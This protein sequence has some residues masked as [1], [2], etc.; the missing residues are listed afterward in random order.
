MLSP[1][2][3]WRTPEELVEVGFSRSRVVM[4]NEAHN[5]L[6]RSVRTRRVGEQVLP[7]AHCAGVRGIAIEALMPRFAAEANE[8]RCVPAARGYL[9]QPDMRAL[10]AAALALG[11]TLIPYECDDRVAPEALNRLAIDGVNWREDQQARNLVAELAALPDDGKLL[12][13][14]GNSHHLKVAAD[15][16]VP[17][18]VRFRELSGIDAFTIDQLRSIR[19]R[20]GDEPGPGYE[21]DLAPLGGTAGFLADE[22]PAG[23][24][25]FGHDA[26]ILSTDNE[27]T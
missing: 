18:G 20:D 26:Y 13:W 17:M 11:W 24:H 22:A 25:V 21:R 7:V 5:G 10:I 8:T 4:V 9:A 6:L 23:F 16:W 19:W 14:C 15:E 3:R 1:A 27:L 12:V 2:V